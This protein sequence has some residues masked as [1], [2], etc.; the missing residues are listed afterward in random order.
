MN[1]IIG[2]RKENILDEM[3]EVARA[4]NKDVAEEERLEKLEA[5]RR[6]R[7][8]AENPKSS[9]RSEGRLGAQ[10]TKAPSVIV[11]AGG[12]IAPTY[13]GLEWDTYAYAAIACKGGKTLNELRPKREKIML[14]Y[15][16]SLERVRN[17]G[18]RHPSPKEAF[19][20][21]IDNLEGRLSEELKPVAEDMCGGFG[22][23][24]SMAMERKGDVL[25]CYLHPEGLVW[26]GK[27]YVKINFTYAEKEQFNVSGKGSQE[28]IN[29]SAFDDM[30]VQ[31]IYGKSFDKLPK[32]MRKGSIYLPEEGVV[33]PAGI[34][35]YSIFD[36]RYN[37]RASRGVK[38]IERFAGMKILMPGTARMNRW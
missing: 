20:L 29:L 12:I 26:D 5:A 3:E 25:I 32:E 21:I 19:S 4:R 13:K 35:G 9:E 28:M 7:E 33:W 14:S 10:S 22:E 2:D 15:D 24:L 23:W 31:Y 34:S 38:N 18:K 37:L 30:L 27:T 36:C 16:K 11:P 1:R 17:E 8:E 6:A